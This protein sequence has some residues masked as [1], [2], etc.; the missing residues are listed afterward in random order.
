MNVRNNCGAKHMN[1]TAIQL[2]DVERLLSAEV[3]CS[4]VEW[5]CVSKTQCLPSE[6][7]CDGVYQCFDSSDED[8]CRT[9][10]TA[11]TI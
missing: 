1:E 7:R 11:V 6:M 3:E 2:Y 5:Q 4:S 9:Y 8:N 10:A